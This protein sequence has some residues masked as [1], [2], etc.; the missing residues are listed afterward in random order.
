[1]RHLLLL[2][3]LALTP[4]AQARTIG[5]FNGAGTCEGCGETVGAF[6][7]ARQDKVI[8][9]NEKTLSAATLA[10]I[11]VYV[12]PGGSDDIDETLNALRPAQIRALRQFVQQGGS[13]LGIC[14]GAYLAGRYSD[15]AS[16]KP[17]FG[18]VPINEVDAEIASPA[19]T[20]LPVQWQGQT[21]WFYHQSAPHL[22]KTA[23]AGAE[24]LGRYQRSGRIAALSTR[25]GHGK[26]LLVGPHLEA[27]RDW[28]QADGLSLQYGTAEADFARLL[29][30]L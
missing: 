8:Y 30:R 21:R 29:D 11:Q 18:L 3:L 20:L 28:Y 6:F 12:Q 19:A 26:V 27:G 24:I 4:F 23:P 14:A 13:Y 7:Q 1:M 15:A 16:R 5:I 17:A 10:K 2:A 25:F 22:G 9:L